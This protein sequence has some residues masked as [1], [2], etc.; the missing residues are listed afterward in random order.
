MNYTLMHKNVAVVGMEILSDTGRI[1][2][3]HTLQ[4]PE[5]LPLGV[6]VKDGISRKVMDD[7]WTGRSI[8]ASRD[9]ITSALSKLDAMS[10][11]MLVVKSYGL[12]L[13][14]QYWIRPEESGLM[15]EDVNFFDNDF[16]GDMG[17]I[18]FGHDPAGPAHISLMSP[19]NTSDGWLRK[20]WIIA[21][22]KRYLMKGSS[23]V[24]Q[25]E[26]F[27]EVIAGAVMRRLGIN[28]VEYTL[29]FSND[30]PYSL[31]ENFVTPE[32]E[33][34]PVWRVKESFKK[35][36]QHSEY[37]H[38]LHCCDKLGI[39]DVPAGLDR[40]L[41]L[42]YIIANED[43]HYNNF[44]FIR[45]ADTLEWLGLAPIYDSGTSL[46]YNTQRVG[47]RV[48]S[49]PFYK[50]H[51][52]QMKLVKDL[53]WFDYD[54]LNGFVNECIEILTQSETIDETR[55]EAIAEAVMG[56][57]GQVEKMRKERKRSN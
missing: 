16:S 44:G 4:A 57:A 31:C 30:K 17:E 12:S 51:I 14:D 43:R 11:A 15:W 37:R 46:W 35:D 8:P 41:T 26:P 3:L 53:S 39:P 49:K 28:H 38:L 52:E 32:T 27:N 54:A 33:L 48:E 47:S 7:W 50:D 23:G 21:D 36:N 6:K 56:R 20:K 2:K 1:V 10:T 25:Q 34:I 45:N 29:T 40:L 24:Y 13:S 55:R 5:H 42:D 22:G 9:G 18:L 19:D